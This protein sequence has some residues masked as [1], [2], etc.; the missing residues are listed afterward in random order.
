MIIALIL[1]VLFA[2]FIIIMILVDVLTKNVYENDESQE[3][4][5]L[6]NKD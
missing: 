2:L 5:N 6:I 4:K 3:E 1:G